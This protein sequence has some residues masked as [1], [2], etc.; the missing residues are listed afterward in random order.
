MIT[1]S[2]WKYLWN[3]LAAFLIGSIFASRY[4]AASWFR[5]VTTILTILLFLGYWFI[6][7]E[8]NQRSRN[9]G[10]MPANEAR[11]IADT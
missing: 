7:W 5:P 2:R 10:A 11:T 6:S 4:A 3:V 1:M 8:D 9:L